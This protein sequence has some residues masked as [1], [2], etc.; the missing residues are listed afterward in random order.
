MRKRPWGPRCLISSHRDNKMPTVHPS[1]PSDVLCWLLLRWLELPGMQNAKA[2]GS[3][4]HIRTTE[5]VRVRSR[6]NRLGGMTP[7]P[8]GLEREETEPRLNRAEQLLRE[9]DVCHSPLWG[10][11]GGG[12][13]GGI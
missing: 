2:S 1:E 12:G 5:L 4:V 3:T 11:A 9:L 10:G 7:Q 13:G 8:G 6:V